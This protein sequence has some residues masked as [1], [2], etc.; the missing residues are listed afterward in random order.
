MNNNEIL[1]TCYIKS[2]EAYMGGQGY[3][4][5]NKGCYSGDAIKRMREIASPLGY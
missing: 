3:E 1:S 2:V 4:G 5:S